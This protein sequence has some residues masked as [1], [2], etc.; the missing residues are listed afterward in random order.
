M[1]E[2]FEQ[3][4]TYLLRRVSTA[5]AHDV[6]K[7]LRR[8]PLT[9]AQYG[10]LAQLGLVDPEALSAATMAERNGITAQSMSTAIAGLLERGLVRREPHPTHGRILQVRITPE[11]TELLARAH[12]STGAAEDRALA[13]LDDEQRLGL[14]RDLRRM[15][16]AMNLYLY[17]TDPDD[18]VT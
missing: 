13:F 12:A 8:F 2:N 1:A 4:L 18:R 9:H 11:G 10:A 5:L 7:A 3:R 16:R 14:G 15:M 17:Q 6:D